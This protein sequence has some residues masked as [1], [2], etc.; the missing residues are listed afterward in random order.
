[1]NEE[2]IPTWWHEDGSFTQIRPDKRSGVE[3]ISYVHGAPTAPA[4][5]D[6]RTEDPRGYRSHPPRQ[7]PKQDQG[8]TGN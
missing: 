4:R 7:D 2:G 1:L 3:G 6:I 5:I 8:K